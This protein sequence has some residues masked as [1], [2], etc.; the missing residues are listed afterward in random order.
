[1]HILEIK[2]ITQT[3]AFSLRI[4]EIFCNPTQN[5]TLT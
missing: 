4:N 1:M 3:K 5:N 2:A